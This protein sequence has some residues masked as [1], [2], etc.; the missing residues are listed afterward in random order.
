MKCLECEAESI[1][2]FCSSRCREKF[3]N[4]NWR[5]R[6]RRLR[7]C[8]LEKLS[9]IC[10]I[11]H[12]VPPKGLEIILEFHHITENSGCLL[13]PNCHREV[14]ILNKRGVEWQDILNQKKISNVE[15]TEDLLGLI[16][17]RKHSRKIEG[18][19]KVYNSKKYIIIDLLRKY[20]E[21]DKISLD[22]KVSRGYV[23]S[24][25]RENKILIP[26]VH[27]GEKEIRKCVK[28]NK[29]FKVKP[30]SKQKYCSLKCVNG[31][32]GRRSKYDKDLIVSLYKEG[33]QPMEIAERFKET[34]I[35]FQNIYH[36]L[37]RSGI[38][39]PMFKHKK[40]IST[41]A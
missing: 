20:T 8:V 37:N 9:N 21:I 7:K 31:V 17:L 4:R 32:R 40:S 34:G 5:A 19:R 1:E 30:S 25:A 13:C 10:Q 12:Y 23:L 28:C 3:L 16:E 33:I 36:I 38:R 39:N 29:E 35:T 14:T 11:C 24:L 22:I 27:R 26:G 6:S 18:P 15:I 41:I 2:K